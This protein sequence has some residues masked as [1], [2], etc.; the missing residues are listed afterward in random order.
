MKYILLIFLAGC[1]SKEQAELKD[2]KDLKKECEQV[3][4]ELDALKVQ[5]L[6]KALEKK[7]N[8]CMLQ[9]WW[10][11]IKPHDWGVKDY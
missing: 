5:V 1:V 2:L 3:K 6:P 11:E 8:Q 7:M 10:K 4:K 9:S